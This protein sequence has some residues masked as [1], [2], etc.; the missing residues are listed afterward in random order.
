MTKRVTQDEHEQVIERTLKNRRAADDSVE[1]AI[2]KRDAE[3][4]RKNDEEQ[5]KRVPYPHECLSEPALTAHKESILAYL[6][7]KAKEAIRA[8][9]D[10]L[11]IDCFASASN[12]TATGSGLGCLPWWIAAKSWAS[13][14]RIDNY[15]SSNTS[16]TGYSDT[17][18]FR[19]Y[20]TRIV[21][22][23]E[24]IWDLAH[25]SRRSQVN[26][27]GTALTISLK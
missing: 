16:S 1:A 26:N 27:G 4:K 14:V 12:D 13:S 25:T 17:D 15:G 22:V 18:L 3:Q 19:T 20:R 7:D 8:G 10:K 5:D 9:K 11:E 24:S 21:R 23:M 6:D 2:A